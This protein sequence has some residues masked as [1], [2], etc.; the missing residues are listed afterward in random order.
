ML[1]LGLTNVQKK[2]KINAN[3]LYR[4]QLK[5]YYGKWSGKNLANSWLA[6][7]IIIIITTNK[8]WLANIM[9][10]WFNSLV[11]SAQLKFWLDYAALI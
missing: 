1:A 2:Q 3:K 7:I 9:N 4:N 10:N 5:T 6:I 11:V 8:N